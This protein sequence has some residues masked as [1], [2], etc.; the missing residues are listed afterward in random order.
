[1]K[2][3]YVIIVRILLILV[4]TNIV[5]LQ[6]TKHEN[7]ILTYDCESGTINDI[8]TEIVKPYSVLVA[9]TDVR[10]SVEDIISEPE[11]T[12]PMYDVPLSK[13]LQEFIYDKCKEYEVD[14][15]LILAII[16]TESNFKSGTTN[17]NSNGSRD[18]GYMQINS[19]HKKEF[20]KQGFTD[21][22]DA[23]QNIE[24]GIKYFADLYHKFNGNEHYSLSSYNR[25]EYGFRKLLKKGIT[26][27]KYSRVV[28]NNKN[29]ITQVK[30]G[31]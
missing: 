27:T 7:N 3:L 22:H 18:H 24:Y 31:D 1:M 23:H 13:E 20:A 10:E 12:M 11:E 6:M 15:K 30:E 2:Q 5:N 26:S 16:K 25:G 9:A 28:I 19:I 29:K 8:K 14:Y 17:K 21:M 4:C